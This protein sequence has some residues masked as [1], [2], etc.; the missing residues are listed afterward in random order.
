MK[1]PGVF[2]FELYEK[3][4]RSAEPKGKRISKWPDIDLTDAVENNARWRDYLRAYEFTLPLE[5][6][7]GQSHI[8]Q[9]TCLCPNGKRL[10]AEFALAKEK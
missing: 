10:S 9:A 4:P 5:S 1:S 7:T 8:L 3:V 6:E 2:R